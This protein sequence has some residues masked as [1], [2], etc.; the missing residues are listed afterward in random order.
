MTTFLYLKKIIEKVCDISNAISGFQY[1]QSFFFVDGALYR[2]YDGINVY[3][4]IEPLGMGIVTKE[5]VT[6]N[7]FAYRET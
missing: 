5:D 6:Y 7:I 2:E 4:I 1:G 3:T